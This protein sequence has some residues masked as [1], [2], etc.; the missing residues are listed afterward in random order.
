MHDF[1]NSRGLHSCPRF[2]TQDKI[3]DSVFYV[4]YSAAFITT[5][6]APSVVT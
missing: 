4:F 5:R 6:S 1:Q 3:D 2:D